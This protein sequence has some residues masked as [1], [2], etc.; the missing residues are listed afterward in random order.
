MPQC[1]AL[2]VLLADA[3]EIYRAGMARAIAAHP[4]LTLIAVA[5]DGPS[6]LAK[7]SGATPDV[8]LLDVRLPKVDGFAVLERLAASHPT[9]S[10]R[11]LLIIAVLDRPLTARALAIGAHGCLSKEASRG[12]ICRTLVEVG[13][14]GGG[15]PGSEP[16]A[17]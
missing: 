5:S 16:A 13:R 12:E 14:G 1:E 4:A 8:A 17:A 3:H 11:V 7:I 6:A 10:T 9:L 2:T 15:R